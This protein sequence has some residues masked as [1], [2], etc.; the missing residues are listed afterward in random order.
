MRASRAQAVDEQPRSQHP[1]LSRYR[2]QHRALGGLR[3]LRSGLKDNG[4]TVGIGPVSSQLV[5][6]E[7]DRAGSTGTLAQLGQQCLG[8]DDTI[9]DLRDGMIGT[10]SKATDAGAVLHQDQP[11]DLVLRKQSR[12]PQRHQLCA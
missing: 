4:D 7:Q 12:L 2:L 6:V 10:T 9:Q 1:W 5:V 8:I 3:G 11:L